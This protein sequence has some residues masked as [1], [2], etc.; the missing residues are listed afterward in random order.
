[1]GVDRIAKEFRDF[2]YDRWQKAADSYH[3]YWTDLTCQAIEPLLNAVQAGEGTR[4]LD[5]ATGPGY[6]VGAAL[7]R[8]SEPIGVDFSEE[9]LAKARSLFPTASFVCGESDDLPFDDGSFDAVTINFGMLHFGDPDRALSEVHRVL[10]HGGHIGFTVW[11][12]PSSDTK[13][14]GIVYGAIETHGTLDV[15]LPPGP[16]FFQY[17]DSEISKDALRNTG[18]TD[19]AVKR[20]NQTWQLPS[21][22]AFIEAFSRGSAR[23][24]PTLHAQNPEA[25]K[26]I[27]DAIKKALLP[28]FRNNVLH[29]PMPAVLA[30]ARKP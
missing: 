12:S 20:I 30:S 24:G 3:Q 14:Y 28:Y 11:A 26:S 15:P 19:P 16:P 10:R 2:E 13:T 17:S 23:T 6:V 27:Y 5:V 18:F 1:M 4:L 22:E 7:K 21:S 9:M 8:G 29:L 25:L